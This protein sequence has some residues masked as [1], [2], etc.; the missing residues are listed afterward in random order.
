MK[1]AIRAL[2]R[3]ASRPD[4]KGHI[5]VKS[6]IASMIV[7]IAAL[8]A[9]AIGLTAG[10]ASAHALISFDCSTGVTVEFTQFGAG[11]S[12][13]TVTVNGVPTDFSWGG[14]DFNANVPF[15]GPAGTDVVV[16]VTWQGPSEPGS[17][18]PQTFST[19]DCATP[20]PGQHSTDPT[21]T[22]EEPT[23]T[24]TPSVAVSP[25]VAVRETE[26]APA[27]VAAPAFTG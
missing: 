22:T 4:E 15:A 2:A 18:G 12:T 6:K 23:T 3:V 11:T 21:P 17:A 26:A 19:D 20:T 1:A 27:V 8:A 24:T 9:G 7:V 14:G 5:L 25:E 16:S 10:A 13:A